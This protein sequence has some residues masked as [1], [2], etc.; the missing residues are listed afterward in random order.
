MTNDPT[1][2]DTIDSVPTLTVAARRIRSLN[3]EAEERGAPM[4]SAEAMQARLF[5]IYDE[6]LTHPEALE[7]IQ[8]HLQLTLARTWYSADEVVALAD[9]LDWLLGVSTPA[10][11][12][13]A[14]AGTAEAPPVDE[15]PADESP[16]SL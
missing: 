16:A 9:Q 5:E 3:A 10:G 12:D 2:Q 15:N 11:P 14:T 4:A 13:P 1:V 8:R 6:A 7:L